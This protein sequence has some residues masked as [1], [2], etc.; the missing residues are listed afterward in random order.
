MRMRMRTSTR[1][2]RMSRKSRTL[3]RSLQ[4]RQVTAWILYTSN[5]ERVQGSRGRADCAVGGGKIEVLNLCK[6]RDFPELS[7]P[8]SLCLVSYSLQ[9]N[10]VDSYTRYSFFFLFML[11]SSGP[12]TKS[13]GKVHCWLLLVEKI[14]QIKIKKTEKTECE[15]WKQKRKP[16]WKKKFPLYGRVKMTN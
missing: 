15:K 6:Q 4:T 11:L 2:C 3:S 7:L 10:Q 5:R 8:S 14:G 16:K 13:K 12:K 9:V 1:M